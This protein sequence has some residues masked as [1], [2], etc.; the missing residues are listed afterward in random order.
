MN[1]VTAGNRLLLNLG[2]VLLLGVGLPGLCAWFVNHALTWD[3]ANSTE[4]L[5]RD[6]EATLQELQAINRER[7]AI[8]ADVLA[9]RMSVLEGLVR[10]QQIYDGCPLVQ[11]TLRLGEPDLGPEEVVRKQYLC[12]LQSA[13]EEQPTASRSL[14]AQIE[15]LEYG[16]ACWP[17][18]EGD[19]P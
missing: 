9:E 13:Y 6:M 16:L 5:G 12:H 3:R 14:L 11:E 17:V 8:L 4:V 18:Q 7:Q 19:V 1:P 10:F 15:V 2:L